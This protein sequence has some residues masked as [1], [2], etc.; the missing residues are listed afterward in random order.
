MR[1]MLKQV[2][3][4]GVVALVASACA[5]RGFVLREAAAVDGVVA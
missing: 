4:V 2:A 3:V 5:T 1:M